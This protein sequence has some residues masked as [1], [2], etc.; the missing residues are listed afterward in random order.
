M[1]LWR[2]GRNQNITHGWINVFVFGILYYIYIC[3]KKSSS[4]LPVHVQ[5]ASQKWCLS[6]HY[7]TACGDYKK[8]IYENTSNNWKASKY[9]KMLMPLSFNRAYCNHSSNH[10]WNDGTKISAVTWS[11]VHDHKVADAFRSKKSLSVLL[12]HC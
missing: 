2:F 4:A 7:S 5:Q 11:I 9:W 6:S 8:N 12:V 3:S 1:C 10:R